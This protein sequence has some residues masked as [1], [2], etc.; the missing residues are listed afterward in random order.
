MP[1][2][3]LSLFDEP[4]NQPDESL[5]TEET[6]NAEEPIEQLEPVHDFNSGVIRKTETFDLF[7]SYKRDN[8][9][10]NGQVLAELLYDKLTADGYKVWLDN[11]E[12]GFSSDYEMRLEQAILHSKKV[13]C[14]IGPAWVNSVNC[15]FELKKAVEFEKR[16]IP[17]HYQTFRKL[18]NE[19]KTNGEITEEEWRRVDKPQEVD[20]SAKSKY[21][22]AYNDLKAICRQDDRYY[23]RHTK[24]LCEA[25]YWVS[26]NRPKSM[27]M[28][29]DQL[30]KVK[31][32]KKKCDSD[33]NYPTF[34][35]LQNEFV[36]ASE[37]FV[38]SEVS[39]KRKAYI[40]Y[41]SEMYDYAAE[42]N[43]ELKLHNVST[44]FEDNRSGQSED[45]KSFIEA[46]ISCE[47][48]L[49]IVPKR[50]PKL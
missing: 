19:K 31:L 11:Q 3:D 2:D 20:F 48:L 9:E 12:I 29:G 6:R 5:N 33:E 10:D 30:A 47:N 28:R 50:T 8:G 41:P 39:N 49:D 21:K 40:S 37:E 36:N 17:L 18:L 44:W 14:V 23:E 26:H 13:A 24:I 22:K 4:E 15:Q 35:V 38:S 25:Y 43:I 27:L 46:I 45:E 32:I 16:I 42:L 34:S 7:I 1:S